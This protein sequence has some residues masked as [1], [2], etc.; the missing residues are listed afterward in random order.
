MMTEPSPSGTD[1][2]ARLEPM[3]C[4][5]EVLLAYPP[6]RH[7][8]FRA[9]PARVTVVLPVYN[10]AQR[11]LRCLESIA[12]QTFTDYQAIII[13]NCSTDDSLAIACHFAAEHPQ[14][15]VYQN[16]DNLGRVG[17][18][19]RGLALAIG[20]YI[21]PLMVN[22]FLLPECLAKLG[23]ILDAHDHVVLARCSVTTLE[24]GVRH[25]G[26]LFETTHCL[27]AQAAIEYCVTTGNPTAGPSAQMLRREAIEGHALRFDTSYEWAADFEFALR[28]FEWGDMYYLRE[29]LY[30][31]EVTNRFAAVRRTGLE[32]R[33]E[34]DVIGSAAA[35]YASRLSPDIIR[36]GR[37]RAESLYRHYLGKCVLEQESA[38]C[39][40]IWREA[41]ARHG[42]LFQEK[43]VDAPA[44]NNAARGQFQASDRTVHRVRRAATAEP[45]NQRWEMAVPEEV[46]FWEKWCRT[47]GGDWREEFESRLRPD[48][49]L[50]DY[51]IQFLD[52]PPGGTLR[53][54]DVGSGPL[55]D[56]G[57]C[58]PGRTVEVTAV[59]PL[60]D[61]YNELLDR[62]GLV[63][64]VRT[65]PIG[66]ENL[67]DH[68]PLNHFDMVYARNSIDHSLDAPRAVDQ[69]LAVLKPGGVMFMAHFISEA[70]AA[71]NTGLHGW[72][73]F[74][75]DGDFIIEKYGGEQ[76]NITRRYAGIARVTCDALPEKRWVT[77]HMTKLAPSVAEDAVAKPM[78]ASGSSSAAL[79]VPEV[80]Q[81]RNYVQTARTAL[82]Q[83]Q[84]LLNRMSSPITK[85]ER[86]PAQFSFSPVPASKVG[87]S[88]PA[89]VP[90]PTPETLRSKADLCFRAGDWTEAGKCYL[91][92]R[93]QFPDDLEIWR[94]SLACARR[95]RFKVLADII[96]ADAL[97]IHP[98]WRGVL[99]EPPA[100]PNPRNRLVSASS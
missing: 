98:E 14:F 16:P 44:A 42:A 45:V 27:P 65:A 74:G 22:D 88:A 86:A 23:A 100:D 87:T 69:M 40:T 31:F 77:V 51:L 70:T 21:K 78:E 24:D 56:V 63:P 43:S 50:Q 61:Q 73:F 93:N 15:I 89:P 13:D 11:L 41:L 32:L 28:L 26:P 38:Q 94:N 84:E 33:D 53:L 57:K 54:L 92:L 75:Q 52:I 64:P 62:H 60:G 71:R 2:A 97:R 9:R 58:W 37:A 47:R 80:V 95:Q 10:G 35:K 91:A 34:L 67:T 20:K 7:A 18:W 48:S 17:N 1:I 12:A 81:L 79:S 30:V 49:K 29:S 90:A 68:F 85:P 66:A 72:N 39:E 6:G 46:H 19:N 59:D 99:V 82:D 4:E 3:L 83:I 96:L 5:G 76:V 8:E 36:R 55:T 25:F